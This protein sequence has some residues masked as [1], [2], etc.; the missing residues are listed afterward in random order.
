M[1]PVNFLG[2]DIVKANNLDSMETIQTLFS[3]PTPLHPAQFGMNRLAARRNYVRPPVAERLVDHYWARFLGCNL[4]LLLNEGPTQVMSVPEELGFWA[5][6]RRGG[7]LV[8]LPPS[9]C[10]ATRD[11]LPDAFLPK[12]LPSPQKLQQL[13]HTTPNQALFGPAA[14]LVHKRPL[15][16]FPQSPFVRPVT[17]ADRSAVAQFHVETPAVPWQLDDSETWINIFGAFVN[18]TLVS[19]CAVRVWGGLLAEIYVDTSPLY[20]R[21]G[22][23]KA[24]TTAALNWINAETPYYP[25]SVV[26]LANHASIQLMK[27]LGFEPYAYMVNSYST[28]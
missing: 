21:L 1:H 3:S 18:G 25:E 5:L 9:F 24:V 26:D 12:V 27:N 13:I 23:G 28:N 20:Q 8:G 14:I 15:W 4:A 17:A 7:W 19:A 2:C 22:Y 10:A 11:A 6:S 16:R